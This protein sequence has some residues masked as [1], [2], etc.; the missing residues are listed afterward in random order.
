MHHVQV[1]IPI[2]PDGR[3]LMRDLR[4]FVEA[5]DDRPE[6]DVVHVLDDEIRYEAHT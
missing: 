2:Q 6:T 3:V 1:S 5:T 4:D